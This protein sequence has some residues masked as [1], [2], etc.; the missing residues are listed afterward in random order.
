MFVGCEDM[1]TIMMERITSFIKIGLQ[2]VETS[3][4]VKTYSR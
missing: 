1:T 4:A 2:M 3:K